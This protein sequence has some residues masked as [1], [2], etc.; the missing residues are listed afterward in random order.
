MIT[1]YEVT[2]SFY[3][4]GT[5]LYF[6]T[7]DDLLK[8]MGRNIGWDYTIKGIEKMPADVAEFHAPN[9][10]IDTYWGKSS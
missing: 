3:K 2:C 5:T 6:K 10:G 4:K 9:W 7:W 1:C 8:Y